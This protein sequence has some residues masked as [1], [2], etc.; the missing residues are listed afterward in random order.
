M[1]ENAQTK[2]HLDLSHKNASSG[3][4]TDIA[5]AL[6]ISAIL[7]N[8]RARVFIPVWLGLMLLGELARLVLVRRYQ[9]MSPGEGLMPRWRAVY[10]LCSAYTGVTWGS[11][12]LFTVLNLGLG[13]QLI[14]I[15]VLLAMAVRALSLGGVFS[16]A[17]PDFLLSMLLPVTLG[18]L[19]QAD[20]SG[21]LMALLLGTLMGLLYQCSRDV[22][23]MVVSTLR[24]A[25]QKDALIGHFMAAQEAER[26]R[27]AHDLHD[28]IGQVLSAI[29]YSLENEA[30]KLNQS[31]AR[32]DTREA[33]AAMAHAMQEAIGEL[34]RI[35]MGLRPAM[36][37]DLGILSTIDW[38]CRRYSA[39]H[40]SLNVSKR[41]G[42]QEGDVPQRLKVAIYR[43]VQEAF[44]NIAKHA[45]AD[46]I[47]LELEKTQT[48]ILLL[49]K[50][51]GRGFDI[52]EHANPEIPKGGSGFGLISMRER[53][54][55]T[56]G[57]FALTSS[58]GGGTSVE[59]CWPLAG[60]SR[61]SDG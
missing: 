47:C 22:N 17:Y 33:L 39:A 18:F 60:L 30:K 9:R 20:S 7:W 2:K 46:Q 36:L 57:A 24:L 6:A 48:A 59:A 45:N 40:P 43:I 58:V 38:F 25:M 61:L 1:D 15:F 5:V 11:L 32:E 49:I 54:E 19:M 14:I 16:L 13:Y 31:P 8:D 42:V 4:A 29:K 3:I 52:R 41:Y 23:S 50:D 28:G 53:A 34:R 51:N 26:K 37:E 35:A 21:A 44:N 56:G 55:G 27:I 10:A 12:G